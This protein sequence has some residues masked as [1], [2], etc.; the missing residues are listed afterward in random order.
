MSEVG[1]CFKSPDNWAKSQKQRADIIFEYFSDI[2]QTY[3]HSLQLENIF[4]HSYDKD[5]ARAKQAVWYDKIEEMGYK[6][7]SIVAMCLEK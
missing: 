5:V 4:S 3:H 2:E 7:F 6:N 1:I